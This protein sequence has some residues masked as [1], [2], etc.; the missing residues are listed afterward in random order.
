MPEWL[1]AAIRPDRIAS[2]RPAPTA[3]RER[4]AL[5]I[6]CASG[7][8]LLF[9][10]F[11]LVSRLGLTSS[12]GIA[13]LASLRFG[14]GGTL[15]LPIFVRYGFAGLGMLRA[16]AL[17]TFG[18]LGF[19]LL[20]YAGFRLVPSSHAA[21]LLHGTLPLFGT[22]GGVLLLGQRIRGRT[23]YGV[24]LVALGIAAMAVAHRASTRESLVGH[25]LLYVLLQRHPVAQVTPLLL[26]TPVFAVTLGVLFWG[27]HPGPRLLL[28]GAL[29]LGGVLI[30]ALRGAARR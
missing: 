4:R 25:G 9:S 12:F 11:T 1:H 28:G 26:L 24:A 30:V 15:L 8:V 17:A 16:A 21:V 22:L 3:E 27:D 13:D 19:A 2:D 10:S 5:G 23:L 18:G 20:A 29:V 14:I 7:V 6:A